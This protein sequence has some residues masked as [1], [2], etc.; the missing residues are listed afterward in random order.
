MKSRVSQVPPFKL[1][2]RYLPLVHAAVARARRQVA[3]PADWNNLLAL[4]ALALQEAANR[5]RSSEP[6]CFAM[7]AKRRV[8]GAILDGLSKQS[9]ASPRPR[10]QQAHNAIQSP[11]WTSGSTPTQ[12]DVGDEFSAMLVPLWK[13]LE[14]AR[15][16]HETSRAPE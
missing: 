3:T 12:T 15:H 9:S 2:V 16:I 11:A 10:L 8:R 4:S 13:V 7:Y 6:V 1:A 14:D 5:Y